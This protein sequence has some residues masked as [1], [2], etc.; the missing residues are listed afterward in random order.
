MKKIFLMGAVVV[1]FLMMSGRLE[2]NIGDALTTTAQGAVDVP[3]GLFKLVGGLLWTV[4]EVI[5][6]PFRAIF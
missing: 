1:A 2:A 3:V 6:L 4:G 5:V